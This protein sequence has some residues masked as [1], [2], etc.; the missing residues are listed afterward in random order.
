MIFVS[1]QIM[2]SNVKDRHYI[3]IR[4]KKLERNRV[5]KANN[6]I[7]GISQ[8]LLRFQMWRNY[9]C[10]S[11]PIEMGTCYYYRHLISITVLT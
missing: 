1:K 6:G 5:K 11:N 8:N 9:K 10:K 2:N 4:S 7:F 3:T